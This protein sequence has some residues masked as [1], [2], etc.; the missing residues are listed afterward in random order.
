MERRSKKLRGLSSEEYNSTDSDGVCSN[1]TLSDEE[2]ATKDQSVDGKNIDNETEVL[3]ENGANGVSNSGE[4][5]KDLEDDVDSDLDQ[6]C[7]ELQRI[8]E[9][10]Q[11]DYDDKLNSNKMERGAVSGY[12]RRQNR[13]MLPEQQ[14]GDDDMPNGRS[15][16][17]RP[18]TWSVDSQ[19]ESQEERPSSRTPSETRDM[20]QQTD[21]S[22]VDSPLLSPFSPFSPFSSLRSPI[23]YLNTNRIS[24][25]SIKHGVFSSQCMGL[26]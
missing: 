5:G 14:N 15:S 26:R 19:Y 4:G 1:T 6:Y 3:S 24:E 11:S 7:A 12:S 13:Y 25:M 20:S 2:E 22:S 17:H 9:L 8:D 21:V 10:Q 23:V 16:K 18:D